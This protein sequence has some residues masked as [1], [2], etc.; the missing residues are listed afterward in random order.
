VASP[1]KENGYTAIANELFD[2]L[3][4]TRIPGEA[5]QVLDYIIRRTYGWN[6]KETAITNR[7]FMLA[8]GLRR[9]NVYRAVKHLLNRNL[10]GIKIDSSGKK[11]YRLNKD[12]DMWKCESKTIQRIDIDSKGIRNDSKRIKSDSLNPRKRSN[13]KDLQCPKDNYKDIYKDISLR[14][15]LLGK[16]KEY[17]PGLEVPDDVS[18]LK[19]DLFLFK[20]EKGDVVPGKVNSPAAYIKSLPMESFPS[21]PEREYLARKRERERVESLKRQREEYEEYKRK[22]GDDLKESIR[23]FRMQLEGEHAAGV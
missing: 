10:I 21:L 1:Q 19:I 3:I 6:K 7:E 9:Q 20:I 15:R 17:F 12:F 8:T 13:G 16:L 18:A 5:R 2:A 4:K 22:N 23:S 11:I 14:E